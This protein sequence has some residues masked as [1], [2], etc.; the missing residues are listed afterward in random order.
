MISQTM[1]VIKT[2]EIRSSGTEALIE[3]LGPVGMAGYL[4]EYDACGKGDIL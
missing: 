4:E 3:A 2:G 1:K